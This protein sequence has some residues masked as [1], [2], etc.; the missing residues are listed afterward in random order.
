M[1]KKVK[2]FV[3]KN[4]VERFSK[5][6]SKINPGTIFLSLC[7][8]KLLDTFSAWGV[9][10]LNP[11]IFANN[12]A[13]NLIKDFFI[14]GNF[15]P[16]LLVQFFVYSLFSLIAL[17]LCFLVRRESQKTRFLFSMPLIGLCYF[18]I[19]FYS[20][21]IGT[22]IINGILVL[23]HIWPIGK[24]L[25]VAVGF[26]IVGFLIK[27]VWDIRGRLVVESTFLIMFL[28]SFSL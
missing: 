13:N 7:F 14:N 26:P 22:N 16:Y 5:W 12:E 9:Y 20:I 2:N 6:L 25:Y 8:V 19:I 11:V 27:Y 23:E 3:S 15:G 17:S 4:I 21:T 10:R 1:K 24:L 18:I 28:V